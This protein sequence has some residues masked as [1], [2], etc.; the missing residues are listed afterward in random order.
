MQ[1]L[2]KGLERPWILL[3]SGVSWSRE[4]LPGPQGVTVLL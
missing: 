2:Q 3:S 1:T 4:S